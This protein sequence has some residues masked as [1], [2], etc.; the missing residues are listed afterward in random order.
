M[1]M[2]AFDQ[3]LIAQRDDGRIV[4]WGELKTW[5]A[6]TGEQR[7]AS[8]VGQAA[9]ALAFA[10]DG[11]ILATSLW[12]TTISLVDLPQPKEHEDE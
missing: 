8:H 2:I 9:Q 1:S 5:D 11:E 6:T 12:D 3:R 7:S 10:D 4:A